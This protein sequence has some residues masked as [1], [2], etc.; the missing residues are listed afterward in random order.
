MNIYLL[1]ELIILIF[2]ISLLITRD[3]FSPA[4]IMCE[5]YILATVS[6]LYNIEKWGMNLHDN[7]LKVDKKELLFIKFHMKSLLLLIAF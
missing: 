2:I 5:P 7:K 6:A 1:L 4:C 3:I